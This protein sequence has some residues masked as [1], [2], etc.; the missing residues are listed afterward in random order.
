MNDR[1]IVPWRVV[2]ERHGFT[3]V[4]T[5]LSQSGD[6]DHLTVQP[7]SEALLSKDGA[8]SLERDVLEAGSL[9]RER[10]DL[11]QTTFAC[12]ACGKRVEAPPTHR[13]HLA[14]KPI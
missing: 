4:P 5:G 9:A 14:R 7:A 3:C 6:A 8:D 13:E 12:L 1:L 11:N 2:G 10:W